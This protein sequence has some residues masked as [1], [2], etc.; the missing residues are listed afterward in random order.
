[1]IIASDETDE[2]ETKLG[3]VEAGEAAGENEGQG[4]ESPSHRARCNMHRVL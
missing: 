4:S 1:M 2:W 3:A